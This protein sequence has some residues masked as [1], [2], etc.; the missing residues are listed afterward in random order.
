MEDQNADSDS[1][2]LQDRTDQ[3]AMLTDQEKQPIIENGPYQPGLKTYLENSAIVCQI[4]RENSHPRGSKNIPICN[5]ASRQILFI[6]LYAVCFPREWEEK[7]PVMH[8]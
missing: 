7:K 8:G 3:P 5:T 6:V 4:S 2:S 1:M